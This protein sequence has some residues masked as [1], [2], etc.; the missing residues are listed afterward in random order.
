MRPWCALLAA[1]LLVPAL[2]IAGDDPLAALKGLV[3]GGQ[4]EFL[5]PDRAF[6]F[7]AESVDGKTIRCA[8]GRGRWLLSLSQQ[9]RFQD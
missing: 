3:G 1:L 6:V 9:V 7:N 8:M 5:K 4:K 2:A